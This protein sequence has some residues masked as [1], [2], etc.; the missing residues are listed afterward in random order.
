MA[1]ETE[2]DLKNSKTCDPGSQQQARLMERHIRDVLEEEVIHLD[3]AF[4][5]D[6][7]FVYE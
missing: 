7:Q 4:S 1:N 3:L 6:S 5:H 2:S